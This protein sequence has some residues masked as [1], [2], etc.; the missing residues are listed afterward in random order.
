MNWFNQLVTLNPLSPTS[1]QEEYLLT[2]SVQ[3][4]A[5]E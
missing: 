4:Q 1:D 2:L 5:D 3:Y